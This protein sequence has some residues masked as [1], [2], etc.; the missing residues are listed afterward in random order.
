MRIKS[1]LFFVIVSFSM[2][3]SQATFASNQGDVPQ[4]C[5]L[6]ITTSAP[7]LTM[8]STSACIAAKSEE[9]Q[10]L[11][12]LRVKTLEK[13]GMTMEE[14]WDGICKGEVT[15]NLQKYLDNNKETVKKTG[16]EVVG[17]LQ[18]ALLADRK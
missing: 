15:P 11:H 3:A 10:K 9:R 14:D 8:S 4:G 18:K 16:P 13:L 7:F 6:T 5:G 1:S 2:S 17:I 12:V